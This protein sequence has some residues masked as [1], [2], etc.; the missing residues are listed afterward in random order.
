MATAVNPDPRQPGRR[1]DHLPADRRAVLEKLLAAR[2]GSL[3]GI[4]RRTTSGPAPLSFAQQRLWFLD[5]LMPGNPIYN[6][7]G[8]YRIR[9]PIDRVALQRA[10]DEMVRRHGSL[11]TTFTAVHGDPVQVVAPHGTLPLRH[12]DLGR[13]PAGERVATAR[14]MADEESQLPFDLATGPLIRATLLR[15]SGTDQILVLTMHHIVSDAWSLAVFWDEL[16][17]LWT[18]FAE[19]RPSPLPE[20]PLQY[21]DFAVW[22]QERFGGDAADGRLRYWTDLLRDAPTLELPSDHPRPAAQSGRGGVCPFTVRS[23]TAD[24][25]RIGRQ[26]HT[27]A[28]MTLFAVF[29]TLLFRYS[30]QQDVVTGTFTADR[31]RAE[32][33]GIIGFFV[34][35]LVLRSDFTGSPTFREVL[36]QTRKT[37][38]DAYAHQEVPFARV[39]QALAPERDPS[40]NP[41]VQAAFQ[42]LTGAGAEAAADDDGRV[43]LPHHTAI[44]DLTISTWPDGDDLSGEIE[45]STDLF[46]ADTIARM[47][48][49]FATLLRAACADPDAPVAALP[50]LTEAE[51]GQLLDRW[52][53]TRAVARADD[54]IVSLLAA[55]AR[56]TPGAVA[57][58]HGEEQLT[59]AQLHERA[60]RLARRLRAAGVGPERLVG[61]C[62]ERSPA[63]VV[64]LLSVLKAGGAYVPLDPSYPRERLALMLDDSDAVVLTEAGLRDKLPDRPV[65]LLE[66]DDDADSDGDVAPAGIRP[67]DLAYVIYTSGSTGR[68]KGVA[69]E[70]RSAAAF[71]RWALD[72]FDPAS[73]AGVLA[74][75]SICFDLSVFELFA[76]LSA[77]G[78]VILA[79]TVLHLPHLPAR[80][81]V[82]LVNSVPSAVG[83]LLHS[84]GLPDGVRVINLAG[85][86]LTESLADT[87]SRRPTLDR[88][89]NLYGPTEATTYATYARIAPGAG[90]PGIGRPVAGTRVY[91]LDGE[92]EPVP[93]GVTGELFLGGAG[94]ARGYLGRPGLTAESFRPD[95]FAGR[96]GERMYRTGD[97][98]RF[99][100]DGTVDFVGRDDQQVKVRGFRIEL[101]EIEAVLGGHP[102]V[103]GA[104]VVARPGA[105]GDTR[106]VAYVVRGATP[107]DRPAGPAADV[108]RWRE[109]W[110]ETYRRQPADGG[111][112]SSYTG[113][114]LP[115]ED[116]RDWLDSVAA[117][118]AAL[119]PRRIL[120]I[121]C[122]T[123]ALLSRLAAGC[124]R[125]CGTDFSA[126]AVRHL[127]ERVRA[128][129]LGHVTVLHRAADDFDGFATG[130]FDAVVLNSVAQY[131]PGVESLLAVVE[132]ALR[133][134]RP[135]GHV[136]FGA[137]RSL[138][139]L[140]AF[141][142]SVELSRAPAALP[143]P[144]LLERVR[145]RVADEDQLLIDPDFFEALPER[146]PAIGGVRIEP[147]GGRYR[148]ELTRF[149][150][151][152][153]LRVGPAPAGPDVP[154][155][156]GWKRDRLTLPALRAR[157]AGGTPAPLGVTGIPNARLTRELA[158]R[159]LLAGAGRPDTAGELRRAVD[160]R[161]DGDVDPE[162]V[163]SVVD[164]LPYAIDLRWAGAG[165]R[166]DAL[167]H[168][169]GTGAAP[170]FPRRPG[171]RRPWP[172]YTNDPAQAVRAR[173]LVPELRRYLQA[174]LPGYMIPAVIVVLDA[175]PMTRNGKVDR[176]ALPV[177]EAAGPRNQESSAP[178]RTATEERIAEIWRQHLGLD[179]VG[180]HDNFFKL[181]GHSLLAIRV[182][183][184]MRET[185]RLELPLP[186]I[187]ETPTIA[188]L[189]QVVDDA[190]DRG[191]HDATPGIVAVSREAHAAV[192]TIDGGLDRG[193]R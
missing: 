3:P 149:R 22:Q 77:G 7:T 81:R 19:G 108:A 14:R 94:V 101:G 70:H 43:D 116:L 69:I 87:L 29:T 184:R 132:G 18:A 4:G 134:V 142:T 157:L 80:D 173:E 17:T 180:A 85:E 181:G 169:L 155:W 185:F 52:N 45:Y 147:E 165:D 48:G 24:L 133:V 33:E 36:R 190:R 171:R 26:E 152:A 106:L 175:L 144:Q 46:E 187:F 30:G 188:G 62:V 120:E 150:Y 163:R 102:A 89:H 78:T 146:F 21:A 76:P 10:L 138:P 123:G 179:Q 121:G 170:A 118:I 58:V 186:V 8:A 151:R 42:L 41:L 15:L 105:D 145:R 47:A 111:W 53:T 64:A 193:Q 35:T 117:R 34:N 11:R 56:R 51:R 127:R 50:L 90:R 100:P 79:D 136:V 1:I 137:V 159:D 189:A 161:P 75:T 63:M 44:L 91:I 59:Y 16:T 93:I 148:N 23:I 176:G 31:G 103:S 49:H 164:G 122:G 135:G 128:D 2:A 12:V 178:P 191:E 55:Q 104:A 162:S 54:T 168:P 107:A 39:V 140:E 183:A 156:L 109:I 66:A 28:F 167:F 129:R 99:R 20:P 84:G 153:V 6:L 95:P 88:L 177:P 96:P 73:L 110:D 83:E 72:A 5:Q 125:V 154:V 131:F 74:A 68:P 130:E 9:E 160:A 65:I 60:D 38:L 67:G 57:V 158:A 115:A 97:L 192:L 86:V 61:V 13:V 112:N 141:H 174:R 119:G 71:L 82:T 124:D 32:T 166:F 172:A 25:H 37:T 98:A 40:R 182:V 113:A 114:S 27:T 143:V 126:V 92:L 139:L